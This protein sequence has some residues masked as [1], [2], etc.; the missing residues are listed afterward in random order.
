MQH[1]TSD[2]LVFLDAH[3][4]PE[5]GCIS[6]LVSGIELTANRA[7][8]VPRVTQFDTTSWLAD[9]SLRGFG[10]EIT[11]DRCQGRWL[12]LSEMRPVSVGTRWCYE[13]PTVV[14]C[15]LAV[16]RNPYDHI[17][18]F[19]P[20]MRTWGSEDVDFGVRAWM[21]GHP[22]LCDPEAGIAHRFVTEFISFEPKLVDLAANQI[23][24]A[25]KILGPHAFREWIAMRGLAD[26][27]P[28]PE[29][30]VAGVWREAWAQYTEDVDA[31]TATE[32]E[33]KSRRVMDEYEYA[34]RF[35]LKWPVRAENDPPLA[36]SSDVYVVRALT[37]TELVEPNMRSPASP[38]P[39]TM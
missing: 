9:P 1:A 6:R 29:N 16:H 26:E 21:T 25:R 23:R 28:A 15:C 27:T 8:M 2:V 34:Q 38:R 14:G 18:G 4:K 37:G 19:D 3:V 5:P 36:P 10:F 12:E 32:A 30:R 20:L 22:V 24:M 11:L 39:G 17:M 33:F 13:S 35:N 31:L 7:V